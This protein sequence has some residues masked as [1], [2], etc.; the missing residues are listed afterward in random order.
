MAER[1]TTRP[2]PTKTWLPARPLA[3]GEPRSGDPAVPILYE[4]EDDM[5][6][7]VENFRHYLAILQ[8]WDEKEK[9][10]QDGPPLQLPDD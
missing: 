5:R 2:Q 7:A 6:E 1:S 8:E 3:S 9:A 10:A 4:D